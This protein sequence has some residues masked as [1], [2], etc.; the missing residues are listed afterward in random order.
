MEKQ[1]GKKYSFN[2]MKLNFE[3]PPIIKDDIWIGK[4]NQAKQHAQTVYQ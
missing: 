2:V 4:R 1:K 3:C